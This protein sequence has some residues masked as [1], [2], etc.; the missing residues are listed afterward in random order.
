VNPVLDCTVNTTTAI[1]NGIMGR[2]SKK[3]CKNGDCRNTSVRRRRISSS[4]LEMK[5]LE[6]IGLKKGS[7]K[8]SREIA[9]PTTRV[10]HGYLLVYSIDEMFA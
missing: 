4:K 8:R 6:K 10:F 1:R 5:A 2:M 7:I 9:E 3:T